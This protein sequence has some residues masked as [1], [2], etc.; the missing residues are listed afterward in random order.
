MREKCIIHANGKHSEEC[1]T[2][3]AC[4]GE[5]Q[6]LNFRNLSTGY[7]HRVVSTGLTAGLQAGKVTCLLGPN[8]AG[9]STLLRTRSLGCNASY[10]VRRIVYAGMDV[11]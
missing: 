4:P 9:K 8:G 3:E 7:G 5:M 2:R 6:V 11:A 10:A 1:A